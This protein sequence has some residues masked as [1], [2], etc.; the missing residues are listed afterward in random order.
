MELV[1]Q[2]CALNQSKKRS[3]S[4]MSSF[5][6]EFF[7]E[8]TFSA[9]A[10]Y[11]PLFFMDKYKEITPVRRK[12]NGDATELENSHSV[13]SLN[14]DRI[15]VVDGLRTDDGSSEDEV[16]NKK[17]KRKGGKGKIKAKAK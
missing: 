17:R 7:A 2:D 1:L 13:A 9:G 11:S 8:K 6:N 14:G 3:G 5:K 15:G 12:E 16:G 10:T 4:P